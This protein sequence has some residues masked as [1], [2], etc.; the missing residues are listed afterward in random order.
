MKFIKTTIPEVVTIEPKIFED[1][2]RYF[3]ESFSQ[4]L[5]E[6]EIGKINFVQDN[7]SKST[8]GALRGLHYQLPPFAQSKLV[9]VVE[10]KVL[11]IAIDIRKGS[12]NFGKYAS[13]ELSSENK[14]QMFIP[15][16]FA[17]AFLTLSDTAI[18]QYKVDNFYS[19]ESEG[20]IIWNDK[21][22][23][24]DWIIDEEDIILSE[25]DKKLPELENAKLF[26]YGANL[27]D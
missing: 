21:T 4:D 26:D 18:F 7:E 13:A 6:K 2:R 14:K 24:V 1:D 5:F 12:P 16:G 10:G 9:R 3:F 8:Y 17:H 11:D 23:D 15:R 19:K 20:G 27:Y 22:I 25:K